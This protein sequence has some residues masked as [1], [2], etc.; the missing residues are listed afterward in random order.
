MNQTI[1]YYNQNAED[2]YAD[3]VSV[4]MSSLYEKFLALLPKQG[5]ILDVGCG[6]GRDAAFFKQQN[7][8]V[9]AFDASAS[10]CDMASD[11]L[12]QPVLN[13]TFDDIHWQ[14]Q[15]AGIWACASLLHCPEERL[16]DV[17]KK[18]QAALVI[19]GILYVSFKYGDSTREK[20][21]RVFTDMNETKLHQLLEQHKGLQIIETWL[22]G[23]NRMERSDVWLNCLIRN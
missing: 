1:D 20:G 11:L 3:T 15:F 14:N 18:L 13:M 2:F 23:D 17:L 16:A 8:A 19:G 9:T 10:L 7:Y 6:S 22:S 12:Q 4:D 5:Q 21:G